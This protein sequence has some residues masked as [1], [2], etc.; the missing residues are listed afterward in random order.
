MDELRC[1][2]IFVLVPLVSCQEQD[3]PPVNLTAVY[4]ADG[5]IHVR[6]EPPDT[7]LKSSISGYNIK[8]GD[9]D[10]IILSGYVLPDVHLYIHNQTVP[11]THY[12]LQVTTLV[13][14]TP[15]GSTQINV[16]TDTATYR[17]TGMSTRLELPKP[18]GARISA[19]MFNSRTLFGVFSGVIFDVSFLSDEGHGGRLTTTNVEVTIDH[20]KHSHAGYYFTETISGPIVLGGTMLVVVD[21]PTYPSITYSQLSPLVGERVTLGCLSMSRTKPDNHGLVLKY[22]WRI[23]GSFVNHTRFTVNDSS[24]FINPVR[25][26]DRYNRFTCQAK[27]ETQVYSGPPSEDSDEFQ[28]TPRYGPQFV[29]IEGVD[30]RFPLIVGDVFGPVVCNTDCN[31]VCEMEWRRDGVLLRLPQTSDNQLVLRD[32]QLPSKREVSYTCTAR[33]PTN[34]GFTAPMIERNVTVQVYLPPRVTSLTYMDVNG[35]VT[36]IRN[37]VI[38]LIEMFN[39]VLNIGYRS[40]P[41]PIVTLEHGNQTIA[42]GVNNDV[43][44]KFDVVVENLHCNHTGMYDVSV[45]NWVTQIRSDVDP[46]RNQFGLQVSCFPRRL[47]SD[48]GIIELIEKKN[49]TIPLNVT[50][51]ANPRPNVLWS[52]G[53]WGLPIVQNNHFTYTIRGTVQ[54]GSVSEEYHVNITNNIGELTVTFQVRP[55][56]VPD[57]AVDFRVSELGRDSVV[58]MWTSNF[59]GGYTQMFDI[60]I[61]ALGDDDWRP[62]L[63]GI[64][65]AGEGETMEYKIMQLTSD[66][67]YVIRLNV[68]NDIGSGK[69]S[70]L[71]YRTSSN[72]QTLG[73]QFVIPTVVLASVGFIVVVTQTTIIIIGMQKTKQGQ[74][75]R[76]AGSHIRDQ[77]LQEIAS[78]GHAQDQEHLYA[79]ADEETKEDVPSTA[80]KEQSQIEAVK[81]QEHL[82]AVADEESKEDVPSTALKEQPQI[83]AVKHQE[84]LYAVADEETKEDVPST[85]IKEQYQIEAIKRNPNMVSDDDIKMEQSTVDTESSMN[86]SSDYINIDQTEDDTDTS[87][88]STSDYINMDQPEVGDIERTL[89][90]VSEYINMDQPEGQEHLYLNC[91]EL[92]DATKVNR[93]DAQKYTKLNIQKGQEHLYLNPIATHDPTALNKGE[94]K[95]YTKLNIKKAEATILTQR[96]EI[97][98]SKFPGQPI[99]PTNLTS[100][101]VADGTIRVTWGPPDRLRVDRYYIDVSD[102]LLRKAYHYLSPE[103]HVYQYNQTKPGTTYTIQV[104]VIRSGSVVGSSET[105]VTTDTARYRVVGT[106]TKL[107]LPKPPDNTI[108]AILHN[109]KTLFMIFHG[110]IAGSLVTEDGAELRLTPTHAELTIVQLNPTHAGYYFTKVINESPTKPLITSSK[111]S[112]VVGTSVTL[113]SSSTS[114]SK[115]DN[116]GLVLTSIWK[117]NGSSFQNDRFIVSGTNLIIDPVRLRD[118]YNRFTCQTREEK[119][120]YSGPPSED[121]DEFLLTPRYGPQF[122]D[123]EGADGR[124]PL[125]VG[126][127]FGPVVCNTDCNP[128]CVMEWRREGDLFPSLQTS[129]NWLF[130]RDSQLP[131]K[132][133]VNYTCTARVPTN[134]EFS[135]AT[136][137]KNVTVTI[138]FPPNITSMMYLDEDGSLQPITDD[139]IILPEAFNLVLSI[140]V[141]SNP[142]SDVTL[143]RN[144]QTV[145]VAGATGTIGRYNMVIEN[146][147]C[148]NT[149]TYVVRATNYVTQ[150]RHN[151]EPSKRQFELRV[152]C[153]PRRLSSNNSSIKLLGKRGQTIPINIT[154]I[155]S[156][157]PFYQWSEGVRVLPTI[158]NNDY[159][160]TIRGAVQIF[161][162]S[163]LRDYHVN[164]TNGLGKVLVVVFQIRPEGV[165]FAPG[166]FRVSE[167]GWDSV[168]VMWTSNFDGGHP[169]MFDIYVMAKGDDDWRPGVLGIQDVGEGKTMEYKII[170]LTSDTDYVIRLNV[171]NDIGSGKSA[172]LLYR[173]SAAPRTPD[174]QSDALTVVLVVV[175]CIVVV[176]LIIAIIII[177]IMRRAKRAQTNSLARSPIQDQ[178]LQGIAHQRHSHGPDHV[179][180]TVEED[181]EPRTSSCETG[182]AEKPTEGTSEDMDLYQPEGCADRPTEGT[183][184]YMELDK[185]EGL[186]HLYSS[187]NDAPHTTEVKTGDEK[188]Y[189]ELNLQRGSVHIYEKTNPRK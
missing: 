64:P 43:T 95:D 56:G 188:D 73:E 8:I 84:H 70:D 54:F 183:S 32:N 12:L 28:L 50:V 88:G 97:L 168:T 147:R 86:G 110:D 85:A 122:V 6:W 131:R 60:Y 173:T 118:R 98:M 17:R 101:Y 125:F 160:Y 129:D 31:P 21:T 69:S 66:T 22:S 11:D 57:A 74:K 112:P 87:K 136:M 186:E 77:E 150:P 30:G 67:E 162:V 38:R 47:D 26:S 145:E 138:Q 15:R 177:I 100:V 106:T 45:A 139:V 1:L 130:L 75:K 41:K 59:N 176:A 63:L 143:L 140:D 146:L 165:P 117:I 61:M 58:V 185:P 2:L 49:Q 120:E 16:T 94:E 172:V 65:D 179:Y 5:T 18:P 151:M 35:D 104:S 157:S 182:S 189:S 19:I 96:H 149:G 23:N 33:V 137:E 169:Q 114:R 161:S 42:H 141:D 135:A 113:G 20:L 105:T 51:I 156:P 81:H 46:A 71:L 171:S 167:F 80:I 103:V 52:E 37:S 109:N 102:A 170:E 132:R 79:V 93:G 40:N 91:N 180:A 9:G 153:E 127:V 142:N 34:A 27:E 36:P 68:S 163:N 115:P 119:Q 164:I 62:G 24:L 82:Y 154:V 116:H 181:R 53:V 78:Q 92:H 178:E 187:S 152:K 166:D 126:D 29:D 89:D 107:L 7:L 174:E 124:S 72:S 159:T 155:A 25:P 158:Q 148:E 76:L 175:V 13:G 90:N 44:G 4:V 128:A 39:L 133:E 121:S 14:A 83:E 99:P 134:A 48:N 144:Q 10:G 123:I 108:T 111:P 55:E 3:I 184:E